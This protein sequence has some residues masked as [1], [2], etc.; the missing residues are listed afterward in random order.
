[1][2]LLAEQQDLSM[3]NATEESTLFSS[4]SIG[5]MYIAPEE[6]FTEVSQETL[7]QLVEMNNQNPLKGYKAKYLQ[8]N[9]DEIFIEK[10]SKYFHDAKQFIEGFFNH[11][12]KTAAFHTEGVIRK[13]Q[14]FISICPSDKEIHCRLELVS[15]DSCRKFHVDN[16]ESR[17]IY[18][19]AGPGSQIQ[20]PDHEDFITLPSGSALIVKGFKYPNFK[21]T[22]L[23]R[24]PPIAKQKIK[25]LLFIAD[26]L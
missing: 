14:Q 13:L 6:D 16:V 10:K 1:M 12:N 3:F 2:S 11:F 18:T 21:L 26:Y 20:H 8:F 23:H 5:A 25:R 19:F 17:L 24:S 22:T 15:G 4:P 7:I 9:P